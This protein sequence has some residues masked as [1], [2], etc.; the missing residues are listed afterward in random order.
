MKNFKI[1]IDNFSGGLT[2][3]YWKSEYPSVGESGQAGMM[4]NCD[5][6][7]PSGLKPGPGSKITRGLAGLLRSIIT[8]PFEAN[9][10]YAVGGLYL[11]QFV[12]DEMT[13]DGT[14]PYLILGNN[15]DCE[16]IK[17]VHFRIGGVDYIGMIFSLNESHQGN[18]GSYINGSIDPDWYKN[19]VY[20]G[21]GTI[22]FK[23]GVPHPIEVIGDG[24]T[25]I[26]DGNQ[27]V[28]I[29]TIDIDVAHAGFS[30]QGSQALDLDYGFVINGLKLYKNKLFITGNNPVLTGTTAT[31]QG[32]YIYDLVSESYDGD[33][34]QISKSG[35]TWIKDDTIFI[36]YEDIT[37]EGTGILGYWDGYQIKKLTSWRG[38][39]PQYYQV[40]ERDGALVWVSRV[41]SEDLI[42]SFKD[43]KLSQLAKGGYTT[44]GGIALPFGKLMMGT[45]N[46]T[47]VYA[48]STEDG[49]ET[50]S[51]W[52]GLMQDITLGGRNGY[53]R[54]LKVTF[55]KIGQGAGAVVKLTDNKGN[56]LFNGTISYPTDSG[57]TQ[58][59]FRLGKKAQ[60]VRAE[61]DYSSFNSTSTIVFFK[62]IEIESNNI[63]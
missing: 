2:K 12:G 27:I 15:P 61:I 58:K 20:W 54:K 18:V 33:F 23:T 8:T 40:A 60:N 38:T 7:D 46:G 48:M 56:N 19:Y 3:Y 29:E 62:S 51:D 31:K 6:S 41:G 36:F 30:G 16:D 43:G 35:G 32:L 10:T 25:Y 44:I 17:K 1:I 26:A 37:D 53:T 49:F 63:A 39:I 22:Q 5:I 59:I 47:T 57:L 28:S 52:K 45:A 9:K 11:Y 24:V 13:V 34:H 4:R 50:D 55:A 42:F 14:Y 21:T